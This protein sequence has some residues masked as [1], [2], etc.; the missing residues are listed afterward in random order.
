MIKLFNITFIM[1][2]IIL[3]STIYLLGLSISI[4][5]AIQPTVRE[6]DNLIYKNISIEDMDLTGH[7]REE[8]TLYLTDHYISPMIDK[9]VLVHAGGQLFTLPLANVIT[10]FNTSDITQAAVSFGKDLNL[11]DKYKLIIHGNAKQFDLSFSYDEETLAS[12]AKEINASIALPPVD[13]Q[14]IKK[15]REH[16]NII[17][18]QNSY[19]LDESALIQ[20]IKTALSK[21]ITE[22]ISLIAPVQ[23]IEPSYT[24]T[25]LS[26]INT[27]ISTFSTSFVGS[28]IGRLENINLSA[29]AINGTIL[30]PGDTFSFNDIV[31]QTTL[32]KGYKKAPAISN[33]NIVNELGGGI[34]QVSSTLYNAVLR[35]GLNAVERRPHSKPVSYVPLGLDATISFGSIDYKFK[36]T[37]DYP[38]YI[39]SYTE[40]NMLYTN[41]YSHSQLMDN[42]FIIESNIYKTIPSLITYQYDSKLSPDQTSIIK[43]GSRGYKVKSYR[44]TYKNSELVN[45]ELIADDSYPASPTIYKIGKIGK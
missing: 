9:V 20:L 32:E 30:M 14:I 8:A 5:S 2:L 23:K 7:T 16:F 31:G 26:H 44:K 45:T 42:E 38:L 21:E 17:P 33:G 19:V 15:P 18:E 41:I 37:F 40:D 4:V 43:Q 12:F 35:T 13:A 24:A 6:W 39:E 36:N 1:R 34:C 25:S 27:L 3:Q 29:A 10:D 22:D 28:S 11:I